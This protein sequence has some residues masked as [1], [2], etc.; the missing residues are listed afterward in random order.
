MN[1]IDFLAIGDITTDAFIRIK[2]ASITCDID[3]RNCKISLNFADKVPYE[4]AEVISAVGNSPNAAV[5]AAR[6]GLSSAL[7]TNL[8]MDIEGD[9]CIE[10]LKKERIDTQYINKQFD[11]K[12]NY[13]YV[14]W[15]ENERTILIKHE[16]YTY[17]LP[18]ITSPVK[19]IYLSSIGEHGKDLHTEIASYLKAH[20]ETKLVFQPGTFQIQSG[21]DFLSE[22][23]HMT[24][25]LVCN[26]EEAQ[27]ILK[28]TE[29]DITIL[30]KELA[31][32]G[33]KIVV[34]TD[35]PKGAY[36]FD[37]TTAWYMP[38]YPDPKPPYERTG[39][40][41]AFTATFA[42]ALL[43]GK[44]V[45]EALMWAPIN[46]MSVVQ[47]VGAQHGLLSEPVLLKLLK[48]APTDYKPKII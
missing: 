11:K 16:A 20:P 23:Y 25:T 13:H 19:C 22:I 18:L 26:V 48:E 12:T 35:G 47:Y 15:Y 37:G 38:I 10:Q 32:L 17:S 40:G 3:N 33:P 8:G 14:L 9:A 46:P 5:A 36:A 7:V 24:Y 4:F 39:A 2:N 28:S 42:I 27:R 44:T 21:V 41:D 34:I 45:E 6:L 30:M 43:K 1:P 29:T 31:A